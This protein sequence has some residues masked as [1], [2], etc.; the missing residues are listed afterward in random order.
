MHLA[1]DAGNTAP[2]VISRPKSYHQNAALNA[3]QLIRLQYAQSSKDALRNECFQ[4][5]RDSLC[6][7]RP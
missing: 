3:A 1:I 6:E 5:L 4:H 2:A 7:S